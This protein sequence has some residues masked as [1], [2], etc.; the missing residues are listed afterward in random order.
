MA[1]QV[2]A[3][4][5]A[6]T[7][8]AARGVGGAGDN[9]EKGEDAVSEQNT[10]GWLLWIDPRREAGTVAEVL[11]R[12]IETFRSKERWGGMAPNILAIRGGATA[13]LVVAAGVAKLTIVENPV[14]GVGLYGL[15]IV[16]K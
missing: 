3:V 12:S 6:R 10:T 9:G 5:A 7:A 16:D 4:A 8:A 1:G 13:E 11:K 2:G 14:I 15:G